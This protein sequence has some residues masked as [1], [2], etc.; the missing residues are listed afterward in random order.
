MK[1]IEFHNKSPC[2]FIRQC[3]FFWTS[4]LSWISLGFTTNQDPLSQKSYVH[5]IW[6]FVKERTWTSPQT[7]LCDDNIFS[8]INLLKFGFYLYC[9]GHLRSSGHAFIKNSGVR[10]KHPAIADWYCETERSKLFKSCPRFSP[11]MFVSALGLEILEMLEGGQCLRSFWS[12]MVVRLQNA[13]P[14]VLQYAP[15]NQPPSH[16]RK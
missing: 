13:T 11:L 5:R 3:H 4:V 7:T 15:S 14:L 16:K 12:P 9:N 6:H 2:V 10:S 1:V 8:V